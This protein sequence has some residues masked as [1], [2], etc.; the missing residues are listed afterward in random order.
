MNLQKTAFIFP[1]FVSEYFGNEVE[2][3]RNLSEEFDALLNITA[4]NFLPEFSNFSLADKQI[5]ENELF[6]QVISYIFGCSISSFLKKKDII[7]E[8]IAGNSMGLYAALQ[9]CESVNFEEGLLLVLKAYE[10]IRNE[11]GKSSMGM[12]AIVGLDFKDIEEILQ[13]TDGKVTIANTNGAFSFL[14]SGEKSGIEKALNRAKN[15]GALF[16]S[17]VPV[18]SPY[19]SGFLRES[20]IQFDHFIDDNI[21]LKDP[22]FRIVSSVDQKLIKTVVDIQDELVK[23]IYYPI[24]WYASMTNMIAEGMSCFV[25]CGAGNSLYKIARFIDGDFKVYPINRISKL[26]GV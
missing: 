12:G 26:L 17:L 9:C 4:S 24:N 16:T 22:I 7:P 18:D 10:L 3:A 25:E 8:M 20:A 23:N 1:A 6:N 13:L 14:I 15:E 5:I 19:H 11:I 21:S 2:I